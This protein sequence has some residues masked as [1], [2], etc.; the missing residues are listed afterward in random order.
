LCM[1]LFIYI[2]IYNKGGKTHWRLA[3]RCPLGVSVCRR[4]WNCVSVASGHSNN[5]QTHTKSV[6][7]KV[8]RKKKGIYACIYLFIFKYIIKEGKLT[9]GPRG[10]QTGH[11]AGG[12]ALCSWKSERFLG[13]LFLDKERSAPFPAALQYRVDAWSGR[14]KPLFRLP[15]QKIHLIYS[16]R[17]EDVS[18]IKLIRTDFSFEKN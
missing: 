17:V 5:K 9:G 4:H 3:G 13:I 18:D 2:F 1:F 12:K 16:P 8:K 10:L 15:V 7:K 14:S 6:S 11:R